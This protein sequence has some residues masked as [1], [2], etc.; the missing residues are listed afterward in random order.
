ML[1]KRLINLWV[2]SIMVN[3]VKTI[4]FIFQ[5][6][7]WWLY[8][9]KPSNS[10]SSKIRDGY[11]GQNHRIHLWVISI[12]VKNCQN[13]ATFLWMK[14]MMVIWVEI[15]K[16]VLEWNLWWSYA[17]KTSNLSLSEFHHG[18]KWSK[19]S[20]SSLSD[21]HHGPKWSKPCNLSLNEIHD[22]Y[23]GQNN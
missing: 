15:I 8:G 23:M 20:S 16:F 13:H 21:F 14:S 22:G 18:K 2:N 10:F 1:Q 19:T 3:I 17:S 9:L 6:Y 5:W 11:M 4:K 12:M 7:P